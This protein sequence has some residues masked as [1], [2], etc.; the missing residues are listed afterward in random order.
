MKKIIDLIKTLLG[1]GS[2]VEKIKQIETGVE[3]VEDVIDDI[4]KIKQ[5]VKKPTPKKS[6]VK[7]TNEPKKK[8]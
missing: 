5:K 1:K 4:K 3:V 7:K 8:K 2:V 6:E